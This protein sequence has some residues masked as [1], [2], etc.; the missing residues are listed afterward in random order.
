MRN[1]FTLF[2]QR[3]SPVAA[4]M[5]TGVEF[6]FPAEATTLTVYSVPGTREVNPD[7]GAAE[8]MIWALRWDPDL[9]SLRVT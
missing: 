6:L 2:H 9:L 5:W 8:P 3:V 1:L 7:R 4:A